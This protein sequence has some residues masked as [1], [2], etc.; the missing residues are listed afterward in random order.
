MTPSSSTSSES[1]TTSN[2]CFVVQDTLTENWWQIYSTEPVAYYVVNLTSI[3]ALVTPYM[4]TTVTNY[5][6]NIYTTNA[7]YTQ[8]DEIGQNPVSLFFNNAPQP[9]EMAVVLGSSIGSQVVTA[10]KTM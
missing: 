8:T 9:A 4:D 7:S 6:T 1:P 2:C 3:T 5:E 10:G